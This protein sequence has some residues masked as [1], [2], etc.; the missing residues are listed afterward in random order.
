M[1]KICE[2]AALMYKNIS[3]Y[4]KGIF[5]YIKGNE[6]LKIYPQCKKNY[7]KGNFYIKGCDTATSKT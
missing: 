6:N 7:I 5:F 1:V 2:T 3:F 4:I